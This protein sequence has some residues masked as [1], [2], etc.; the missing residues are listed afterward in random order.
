VANEVKELAKATARA[1]EDISQKIETIQTDT[2]SVV[3]A[4]DN[5]NEIIN[6]ISSIQ[7]T[8]ACAVEVQAATSSEI[9]RN[10]T[11]AARGSSEI[12]ENITSVAEAAA[13]TSSGASQALGSATN[14]STIATELNELVG[15]FKY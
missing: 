2:G 1:T 11:E 12:A 14:L 8:I 10:V 13:T 7:T 9:G 15:N 4:I 3:G 6:Q 5:I